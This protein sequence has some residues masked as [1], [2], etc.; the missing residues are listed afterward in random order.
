MLLEHGEGR[1]LGGAYY[2]RFMGAHDI[3]TDH[4]VGG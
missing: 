2:L 4:L 1:P 3:R